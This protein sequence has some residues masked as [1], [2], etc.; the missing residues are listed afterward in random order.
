MISKENARLVYTIVGVALLGTGVWLAY[1]F[2]VAPREE[3]PSLLGAKY[4][5]TSLSAEERIEDLL[6]RMTLRE[7]IGQMALVEKN[8]IKNLS[9]VSTYG[10]G[11]VLS[12]GGAKPETNTPAGWRNMI[13]S[14]VEE[15]RRSRLGVPI[16]YGVDAN[17]GQ[18][19]VP[20]ATIFPHMIG[21]SAAGDEDLAQRVARATADESAAIG[22]TWIY[23]PSLDLP[24]DIRWGRVYETFGDNSKLAGTLG[25]AFVRGLQSNAPGENRATVR[26]L[27]TPKH[28]VGMGSMLW[29]SSSSDTKEYR[30]DQGTIPPG[31][32][33][34]DEAYLPPFKEAIDAGALSIMVGLA[35]WGDTKLSASEYLIT[36]VLKKRLGFDGFA[37]S[38]WY[39]VYEISPEGDDYASAIAGINAG[40]DMVMLPYDY[41]D[42]VDNVARAVVRGEIS[43]LRIDDAVRRILKAK[44]AVGFTQGESLVLPLETV[45]AKEHRALARLAVSKSLVLLKNDSALLPLSG[46]SRKI[47]VAGSGAD[48]TGRQSGG[49]TIEWQGV[50]GNMIPGATSILQGL[51]D[52]S[53]EN[54]VIEFAEDGVFTDKDIADVGIAIVSE[55]PY[56]EGWGDNPDPR[57]SDEDLK[58]I[59]RLRS[60]VQK[61][62]VI[63]VAGRPLIISEEISSW[64][65]AVMAWLPGSEG[66]G[67]ADVLFGEKSFSGKLPLPWPRSTTQL[68]ITDRGTK[69]GTEVLFE[70][71][72]GLSTQ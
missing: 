10:F 15:S 30:I 58:A 4:S 35:S 49:W 29:G 27:A 45:G 20:G 47:R 13:A 3:Y 40:I 5:D 57:I 7:K 2:F 44:F 69:D 21:L 6:S 41:E 65:A 25:A 64:D 61:L 34:L 72:F 54:T 67:V 56:A 31:E 48:N 51:K 9:D 52:Q 24:R 32:L 19:N 1:V 63:I 37:V 46:D 8:S 26:T 38:D 39:G 12:G 11:A 17:H 16:L 18:G 36:D 14:L 43:P 50:D 60:S 59:E 33:T 62:I 55:K 53:K 42:F 66:R 28:Y 68:P 23:S 70:R 71:G 22:A